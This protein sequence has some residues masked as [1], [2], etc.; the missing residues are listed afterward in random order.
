M[1]HSPQILLPPRKS[2]V[3]APAGFNLVSHTIGT[4]SPG[5]ITTPGID[6]TGATLIVIGLTQ[7]NA[8][9]FSTIS[10]SNSNTWTPLTAQIGASQPYSQLFY[11]ISPIVGPGHTF[12]ATG[13]AFIVGSIMVQAWKGGTGTFDVQSGATG[14]GTTLQTGS[15][16][17][18]VNNSLIVTALS[19]DNSPTSIDSVS[20]GFAISDSSI[21]Q[22]PGGM[23]WFVQ[24]TAAA[25]NPTWSWTSAGSDAAATIATFKP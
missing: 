20:G 22:T 18:S 1:L 19:V 3:A 6:T 4:A 24:G 11:C 8:V 23:A 15:V 5:P 12:T 10:D 14:F 9:T 16:T 2:I 25:I 7:L 21:A 17:P 13:G